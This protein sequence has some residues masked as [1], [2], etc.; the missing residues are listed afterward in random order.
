MHGE[1]I[2]D[3]VQ[4]GP[5]PLMIDGHA[6]WKRGADGRMVFDAETEW[7]RDFPTAVAM[8]LGFRVALGPGDEAGF[9]ELI[10]LG[11][12]HSAYAGDA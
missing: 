7:L 10:V 11:L 1:L 2:S 6:S 9:D 8:G 4:A 12:K 3:V 5:T